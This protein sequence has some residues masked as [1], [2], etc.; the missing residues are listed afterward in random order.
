MT[1]IIKNNEYLP[2]KR[3]QTDFYLNR[4]KEFGIN[5]SWSVGW[6]DYLQPVLFEKLI[7]ILPGIPESNPVSLLD[8]GC[9]LGDLI[10]YLKQHGYSSIRYNGIDIIPEMIYYGKIKY[11]RADLK[12][13]DFSDQTF[14]NEYDYIVCSGALNILAAKDRSGHEKYVMDFIKKMFALSKKG[15]SFNL[16][17]IEGRQYFTDDNRFYYAERNKFIEFCSTITSKT[18]IDFKDNDF[19][20]TIFMYK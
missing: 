15:C 14:I 16:L 19:I 4:L 8:V 2:L 7:G 3:I 1:A 12:I 18:Y 17:A 20:F 5:S 6:S 13:A 10:F 9:G 11:P